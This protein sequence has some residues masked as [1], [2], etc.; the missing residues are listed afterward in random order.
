MNVADS[1]FALYNL[2]GYQ[3]I[4]LFV[5]G[6]IELFLYLR[7]CQIW[8]RLRRHILPAIYFHQFFHYMAIFHLN[9]FD[10]FVSLILSRTLVLRF[11]RF[12]SLVSGDFCFG[13]LKF[14]HVE[15]VLSQLLVVIER[16]VAH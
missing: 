1:R 9:L 10:S 16:I 5:G 3:I 15:L 8:T 4:L 12:E 11:W 7:K 6:N 14:L 2:F 13:I